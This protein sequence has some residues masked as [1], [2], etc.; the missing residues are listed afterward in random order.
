[1]MRMDKITTI[2]WDWNGTLLNDTGICIESI[3]SMLAK[4]NLEALSKTRY[5]E[6]FTFPVQDYYISAG[7]D[8]SS[9]TWEI[10]AMEFMDLYF[11]KL[12]K[13][14][15][16]TDAASVLAKLK[17]RKFDQVMVSAMEHDSLIRSV[18]GKGLY[19]FFDY[20]GGINDHY[21]GGKLENAIYTMKT[22]N[23]KPDS[24]LLIGD[25]IHDF[26][27]AKQI[28]ADCILI[29]QGHQSHERLSTLDCPVLTA[30]TEIPDYFNTQEFSLVL[31]K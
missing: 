29:S 24:T 26:E 3:N 20:I 22:L 17:E 16:F 6:I 15:I 27:V 10:V 12:H 19:P 8:F 1:M 13:A 23:L 2:I 5:R 4:R 30:L 11:S 31:K 28:G 18:K 7:F 21:A 9:E 14:D 25:T